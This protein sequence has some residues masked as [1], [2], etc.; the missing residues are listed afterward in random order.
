M[1][2]IKIFASFLVLL[3]LGAC[4][5]TQKSVR[6]PDFYPNDHL[7]KVGKAQANHDTQVCMSLASDYVKEP[8]RWKEIAKTTGEGALIGTATGAVGGA[9]VSNAGR[10]TGI[11]A[12]T[13][14]ILGLIR[15]IQKSGDPNPTYE[16]FVE[17]C[18]ADKGYRVFGWS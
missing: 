3:S 10:G 4:S 6:S 16:R 14:A 8:E 15:G 11:G 17:Q 18:L 13:G 5:I 7:S 9:I 2:K 12:A 1:K